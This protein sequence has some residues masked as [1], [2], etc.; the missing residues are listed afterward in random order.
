[1]DE[2]VDGLMI[3]GRR[4]YRFEGICW[5]F[6][7]DWRVLIMDCWWIIDGLK[8]IVD[9][10]LFKLELKVVFFRLAISKD[11]CEK[12]YSNNENPSLS[13]ENQPS[14]SILNSKSSLN[15]LQTNSKS[16]LNQ[17]KSALTNTQFS[18]KQT[19]F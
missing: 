13:I 11:L 15:N 17:F 16:S 8:K 1:M 19:P 14:R 12:F 2:G 10:L 6:E 4:L 7:E 9:G 3:D 5:W 18:S